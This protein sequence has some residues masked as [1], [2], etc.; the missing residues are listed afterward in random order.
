VPLR[1]QVVNV[2]S[3]TDFSHAE[4]HF[5]LFALAISAKLVVHELDVAALVDARL[6]G[7]FDEL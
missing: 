6:K 5:L 7:F 3:A 4:L 2:P 1:L